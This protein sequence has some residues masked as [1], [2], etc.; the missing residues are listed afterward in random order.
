MSTHL[1]VN[2]LN[3][4]GDSRSHRENK[5]RYETDGSHYE[6][7]NSRYERSRRRNDRDRGER[8]DNYGRY[9]DDRYYKSKDYDRE[10]RDERGKY[11]NITK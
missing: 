7:E 1:N 3:R 4:Y 9:R 10:T 6:K 5:Y 11:R 8:G 2:V